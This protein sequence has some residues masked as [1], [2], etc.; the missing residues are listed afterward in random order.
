MTDLLRR[1]DALIAAGG[2]GAA[3]V[4][5]GSLFGSVDPAAAG[6]CVLLQREVT[7]GPYYLDLDLVRRNI[8]EDRRGI[9][10][11]L[12]FRVFNVNSCRI[13]RHAAVEIWHADGSGT[14][15]GVNGN[16]DTYLSPATRCTLAR[17]S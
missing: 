7:E 9:P 17:C 14:Y 12:R 8:K 2:L 4:G 1:R 15:S 5:A 10:L 6:D 13:I 11:T 3:A 16:S